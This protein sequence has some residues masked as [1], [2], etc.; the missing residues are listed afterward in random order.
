MAAQEEQIMKKNMKLL[1][2]VAV[3]VVVLV[4][5][6]LLLIFLPESEDSTATYDEGI[7][8]STST[9][10]E[11]VHQAQ[12]NT[13]EDGNIENNSYGTLLDYVPAD[14]S[15]IHVENTSGSFDVTSYTPTN[16]DGE[17]ETT[18]YTLVGY[19][20]FELQSG[21]PDLIASSAAAIKFASVATLDA[22]KSGEYGFDEPRAT[23][24]VT[25][26]DN[27][28]AIIIVGDDAPQSAGTYIK[29][30]DGDAVY[31]VDADYATPFLY[32]LTDLF[33]LTINDSASDDDDS[34]ASSIEL[35]GS[36][37]SDT[38]K[39]EP[40]SNTNN[41]ASYVITEP[42]EL[43]ASETGSSEIEGAIRGLYA[44]S[45]AMV[46]PSEKQLESLG[47]STPY[48]EVKAVYPDVEVDLIASQSDNEGYVYLMENGGKVVYQIAADSVPWV[49][50]TY[51]EIVSEYV[52]YPKMTALTVMTVNNGED[53]YE[54]SLSTTETTTTDDDGEETTTTTTTVK[55]GDDEIEQSYFSTFYQNV[56]LI[57]RSDISSDSPSG[58][59]VYSITYQYSDGTSDE[60]CYYDAGN[61][62]Y[63]ATLNGES[64]GHVYKSSITKLVDQVEDISENKEVDSFAA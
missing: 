36:N 9:D 15:K 7:S 13:D 24:T 22:D 3:A 59:A 48:A 20:D 8:M 2:G 57:E 23:V 55:Y 16:E 29:F 18:E 58:S 60:V 1:I 42:T 50:I 40:N 56:T 45:V 54:F 38:I 64:L 25:Y 43:F 49:T 32:S 26:D 30:G 35:S 27:T 62:R 39:L 14:I 63:L 12:I 41:S 28:T 37:F 31:V 33:S 4:G 52:L 19:E 44:E 53:T 6:M 17:A 5:V 34:Q 46:N 11:G 51:D 10:D 47:L 61:N 21:T